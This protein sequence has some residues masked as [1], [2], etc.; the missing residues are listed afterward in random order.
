MGW[1]PMCGV[2][3]TYM[4]SHF[5]ITSPIHTL[6]TATIHMIKVAIYAL[7][8]EEMVYALYV[9]EMVYVL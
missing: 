4:Y 2:H 7:Y 6:H 3:H 8:V 9:E 5:R 1:G